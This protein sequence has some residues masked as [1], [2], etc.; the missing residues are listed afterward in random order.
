MSDIYRRCGCRRPDGK[1]YPP[2]PDRPTAS[3]RAAACPVL[4]E[5]AKH[6]SWGFVA[7]G[8]SDPGTGRRVRHRQMGFPTKREA[9]Q[10]RSR[11]VEQIASRTYRPRSGLTVG[12]YL[13]QWIDGREH[14]GLKPLRPSTARMYR[15]YIEHDIVP[16]IGRLRVDEVT[17]D[18]VQRLIEQL[19]RD[20]RGPVTVRRI[21]AT[22]ASAFTTARKRK[23]T[24]LSP[25]VDL[26]L[27]MPKRNKIR[28]WEASQ[29]DTFLE[30]AHR[31][32]L[33]A[34]YELL[35]LTGLRRGEVTALRW[36]DIDLT[37]R[38]LTVRQQRVQ[39]GG[40]VVEGPVKTDAGQEH[41]IDLGSDAI[42]LLVAQRLQ[43]DAERAA[44]GAAYQDG[45]YVFGWE[46]GRPFRPAYVS[47][48]F[49]EIVVE[50]GLPHLSLHGLRHQHAALLI[51]GGADLAI[52][53]K[54]LG[55]STYAITSDFYGHLTRSAGRAAAEAAEGLLA[56]RQR[57]VS[58]TI[59]HT[60]AA[61]TPSPEAG[62]GVSDPANPGIMRRGG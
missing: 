53:S 13:G 48:V 16:A 49:D 38:E 50:A 60:L 57:G 26:D 9:Q 17:S 40:K 8:G 24:I 59:G 10:A 7:Y 14:L 21:H 4:L 1:L 54:R 27:P 6:G 47:R 19:L 58:N 33:G 35:L 5:D 30:Y 11:V 62:E 36:A 39:L 15:S 56:P 37:R 28:A 61:Q 31:R 51:E 34:L 32:R 23:L 20:G 25:A 3:Q 22:L 46:D 44:W 42:G 29:V 12:Q 2:L 45:G 41:S 43:Q 55:H 52:V 18:D